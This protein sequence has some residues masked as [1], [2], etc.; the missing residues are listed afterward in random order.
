MFSA[1]DNI[2]DVFN[3]ERFVDAQ[4]RDYSTAICSALNY[5]GI[6]PDDFALQNAMFA[7]PVHAPIHGIG[8]IYRTMIGCAL[9]GELLQKPREGLL[10]FCGAFVHDLARE[11]DGVDSEHGA[12]AALKYFDKFNNIWDKYQLTTQ[13]RE[14]VKQAV[15]QHSTREWMR[16]GDVGY[17]VMAILK[18]ADALDR[19]RIGDLD[20]QWL[21]YRDSRFLIRPIE[22]ICDKT[23]SVNDDID[24]SSF[25]QMI[26]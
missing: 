14:V 5:I 2:S 25:I 18:D 16:C 8:H 11:N 19:C 10:A 23:Y 22:A 26:S 15:E 3:L 4:E 1:E 20:P 24:F 7:R 17:D 6:V 12:N 9:L 13:E 21:R